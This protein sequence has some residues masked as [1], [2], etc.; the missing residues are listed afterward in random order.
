M[1]AS[2]WP[3]VRAVTS[4][5]GPEGISL[6]LK[7]QEVLSAVLARASVLSSP[8]CTR[9]ILIALHPVA[10]FP[11]FTLICVIATNKDS[12]FLVTVQSQKTNS[13]NKNQLSCRTWMDMIKSQT[14]PA[15]FYIY[16]GPFY[17]PRLNS[18][19]RKGRVVFL[20]QHG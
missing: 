14:R 8:L 19:L 15:R 6:G 13:E 10:A 16:F 20:K 9:G 17:S 5:L 7:P 1:P 18:R 11:A 12:G 3:C 4:L 2:P